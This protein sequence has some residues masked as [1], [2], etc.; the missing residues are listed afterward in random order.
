[1][2]LTTLLANF[3]LPSSFTYLYFTLLTR[4]IIHDGFSKNGYFTLSHKFEIQ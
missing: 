4:T 2:D 3:N 1:M